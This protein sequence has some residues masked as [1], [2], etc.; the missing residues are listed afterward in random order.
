MNLACQRDGKMLPNAV[1]ERVPLP[2]THSTVFGSLLVNDNSN[3]P[4]SD[5]T[6]VRKINLWT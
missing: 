6:Q 4:Y 1:Y 3:T 5:A 2:S